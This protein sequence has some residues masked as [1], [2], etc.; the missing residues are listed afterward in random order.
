MYSNIVVLVSTTNRI[1]MLAYLP[2]SPCPRNSRTG[3]ISS[4]RSG[5]GGSSH[6]VS[7]T[8]QAKPSDRKHRAKAR[9][10]EVSQRGHVL[11]W[12]DLS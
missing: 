1:N 2:A 6:H 4:S 12:S 7:L 5:G 9:A 11:F 8:E 3:I 10:S